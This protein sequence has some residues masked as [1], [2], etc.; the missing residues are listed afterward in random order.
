MP[1]PQGRPKRR[2]NRQDTHS[3]GSGF[4]LSAN[5]EILT[6]AHVVAGADQII[7]KLADN[8]EK[9]ATVIGLDTGSDVALLKIDAVGLPAVQIGDSAKLEVGD[10]VLA[11]GS[12]WFG[13]HGYSRHCQ[14]CGAEPA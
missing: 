14:R 5:G 3:L 12:L 4:I 13:A 1:G 8:S 10:W 7:V 9:L 11:I 6:N 2:P